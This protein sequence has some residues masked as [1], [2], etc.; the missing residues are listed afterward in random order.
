MKE[1]SE[2]ELKNKAESYCSNSEHCSIEVENKLKQWGAPDE[3]IRSIMVHLLKERYIDNKRFC[4]AFVHDKYKFNR[5]GRQRIR[6][7]LRMKQLEEADIAC[8]MEEIDEKEYMDGLKELL[9]NKNKGVKAKNDYERAQKL[10][11]YAVGRGFL[12]EEV[13]QCIKHVTADEYLD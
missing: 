4:Q 13:A 6:Q 7:E 5:W 1:Y 9:L 10:M 11:R 2:N 8:G 12:I 3:T